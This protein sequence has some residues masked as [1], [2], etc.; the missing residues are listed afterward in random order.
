VP[1]DGATVP[2]DS[3]QLLPAA[4]PA[5][6]RYVP[7]AELGERPNIIVDGPPQAA[8]LLTLSHWPNNGTPAALK[9]D[10][11][12]A[13]AFAYLDSPASHCDAALVSNSHFDEDGLF[14]MFVL[15]DPPTALKHRALLTDASHAG[16]FGVF[17]DRD[18]ARLAFAIETL[19]DPHAS[20]LP[21]STFAVCERL[22]TARLYE[23][24]LEQ[25]PSLLE[26][27]PGHA[28]LWAEQDRHL[29]RSLAW[30]DDGTVD[31]Q[32]Y[33][34][35]DLA[36][37]RM[38]LDLP[39]ATARRYLRA[40]RAPVHPFAIH[41]YTNCN[42]LLRIQ[43]RRYELQYRYESWVQ[44]Q[45][46]R[47][48]L[49]VDLEPLAAIL[50]ERETAPGTWHADGVME[51]APR[52]YLDG[53]DASGIPAGEFIDCVSAHLGSAPVAWDPYDWRG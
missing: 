7:Y 2:A 24:M 53:A 11:S 30:F 38:P 10:T 31:L 22:R 14:S 25:L 33:P 15:V 13:I 41:R 46:R 45:S 28:G 18:A 4:L 27:L 29:G 43:G 5:P 50:N 1:A 3:A 35:V 20:P 9:R 23:A 16:D 47:P 49:R 44:L 48:A 37:V 26:D 51:V 42:R 39:E 17:A 52:L 36:V 34:A 6:V 8:T 21:A 40:E 32:E 19:A 12:T